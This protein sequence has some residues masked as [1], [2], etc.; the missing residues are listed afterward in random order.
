M[1]ASSPSS[2]AAVQLPEDLPGQVDLPGGVERHAPEG[3][4]DE[5]LSAPR[6][7]RGRRGCAEGTPTAPGRPLPNPRKPSRADYLVEEFWVRHA[8]VSTAGQTA[9]PARRPSTATRS[10][11]TVA[12]NLH[13]PM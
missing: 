7:R 4:G 10:P 6:S 9:S 3:P 12:P 8:A 2:C 5:P 11:W 13:C 1:C